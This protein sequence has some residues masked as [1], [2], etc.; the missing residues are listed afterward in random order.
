M[1]KLHNGSSFFLNP[2]LLIRIFEDVLVS[3]EHVGIHNSH[4][5]RATNRAGTFSFEQHHIDADAWL[6]GSTHGNPHFRGE[7]LSARSTANHNG[8]LDTEKSGLPTPTRGDT[9]VDTD[10]NVFIL[11][12]AMLV[13]AID[14][15][16]DACSSA[17][18]SMMYGVVYNLLHGMCPI[19]RI[20]W[21]YGREPSAGN[22]S[23]L[24]T[25]GKQRLHFPPSGVFH[26][27]SPLRRCSSFLKTSKFSEITDSE[28]SVSAAFKAR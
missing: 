4:C 23:T 15:V 10:A 21:R 13:N 24:W 22:S 25:H 16:C 14:L 2:P 5:D 6:R 17:V 9:A 28:I 19:H 26:G 8:I 27:V 12:S 18:Y 20:S 11:V 7:S 1:Q 3:F